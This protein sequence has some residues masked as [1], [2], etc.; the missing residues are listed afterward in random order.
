MRS[1]GI[2]RLPPAGADWP[3]QE[4]GTETREACWLGQ[5]A[6]WLGPGAGAGAGAV[7]SG[8][9][10]EGLA[11]DVGVGDGSLEARI[12]GGV[13][14]GTVGQVLGVVGM[15]GQEMRTCPW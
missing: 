5:G 1:S 15:A 3:E 10:P 8:T 6:G 9:P 2:R 14:K 13:Q 4:T 7:L 12:V 11:E